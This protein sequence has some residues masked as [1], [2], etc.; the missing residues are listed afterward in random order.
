MPGA[1]IRSFTAHICSCNIDVFYVKE[2][3]ETSRDSVALTREYNTANKTEDSHN[4]NI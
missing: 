3:T 2:L 1:F 4:D